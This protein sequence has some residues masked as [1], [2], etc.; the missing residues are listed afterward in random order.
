MRSEKTIRRVGVAMLSRDDLLI[1]TATLNENEAIQKWLPET[2]RHFPRSPILIVDDSSIDGTRK[3]LEEVGKEDRT[4]TVISRP[5]R[6]G[7][8]SAHKL[9]ISWALRN[10]LEALLTCDA[11][12][13][14]R[15]EDMKAVWE[16]STGFNF[17]VGS[18][19]HGGR[20]E[21]R[22]N[23]RLVTSCSNFLLRAAL[24]G[25]VSEYTTSLRF[26]DSFSLKSLSL[27]APRSSGYGFFIEGIET[28][29]RTGS[30]M[31]EAPIVFE[32]RVGGKSKIPRDQIIRSL[33]TLGAL[34]T[35]RV[36]R[37]LAISIAVRGN[38]LENFNCEQ[39]NYSFQECTEGKR[40]KTSRCL[41]C[42]R[43]ELIEIV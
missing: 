24:P 4:I 35:D 40:L 30:R 31:T 2:R 10:G 15:P 36:R 41:V 26:Y 19:F 16:A 39:C 11:D 22:W 5:R 3:Y 33:L 37:R 38:R 1:F 17:V 27:E 7:L 12:M 34:L 29:Y 28:L 9:A 42:G 21:T 8:G 14:H 43:I 23:R 6:L 25:P 18:R 13:S 20:N 32:D